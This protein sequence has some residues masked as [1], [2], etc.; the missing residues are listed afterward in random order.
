[1][2]KALPVILA[3]ALERL[4]AY[5]RILRD[6]VLMEAEELSG[7][8]DC[9]LCRRSGRGRT[10]NEHGSS[11]GVDLVLLLADSAEHLLPAQRNMSCVRVQADGGEHHV[12]HVGGIGS[13]A[14][15]CDGPTLEPGV[16]QISFVRI[17]VLVVLLN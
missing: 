8:P 13:K 3:P 12:N 9:I 14:D 4:L 6:V 1:M 7:D 15:S 16:S 17:T 5:V 11:S 10:G 2:T